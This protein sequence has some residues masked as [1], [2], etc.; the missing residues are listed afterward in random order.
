MSIDPTFD[1]TFP[2]D[3]ALQLSP[4][5]ISI[6]RYEQMPFFCFMVFYQFLHSLA[7]ITNFAMIDID[8]DNTRFII[9]F[10]SDMVS[11]I[12]STCI[13]IISRYRKASLLRVSIRYK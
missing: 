8:I 12:D 2:N 6:M 7:K 5:V 9:F 10:D 11:I 13:D 4:I 1:F 3:H